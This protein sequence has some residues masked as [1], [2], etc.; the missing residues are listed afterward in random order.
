MSSTVLQRTWKHKSQCSSLSQPFL[1]KANIIETSL[2]YCSLPEQDLGRL[3]QVKGM[4]EASE[5]RT[6]IIAMAVDQSEWSE[7]AFECE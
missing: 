3:V 5:K 4:A 7:Q 2:N 6:R 1:L